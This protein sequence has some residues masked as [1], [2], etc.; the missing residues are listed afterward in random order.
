MKTA[1]MVQ[2]EKYFLAIANTTTDMI[3]LNNFEGRIVYTNQATEEILGYPAGELVN[4]LAFSIIHPDDHEIIKNDMRSISL[5]NNQLPSREIR[6]LKKD[7][8]YLDVEVRG[9]TVA[10]D[11][12]KTYLGA[13]IR[14]ISARKQ[15]EQ[16]LETYRNRLEKL[17]EERTSKL[18]KAL[19][20]VKSLRGIFPICS[21]CKKIRDDKGYWNQVE[22]YVQKHS[23]ADFSHSVC[24][25][26]AQ[27][28]YPGLTLPKE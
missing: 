27:E 17:V 21:F 2:T 11:D 19:G 7:G 12:G 25:D 20:E 13:I 16:E 8:Q 14:D 4:S 5:D 26:C 3:H 23:E 24:P 28:H 18:Q 6:L 1:K 22:V 15:R 10:L 9:F